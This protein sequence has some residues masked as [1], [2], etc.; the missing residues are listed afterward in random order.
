MTSFLYVNHRNQS[1]SVR[2]WD[3]SPQ[4][5]GTYQASVDLCVL[6]STK[7]YDLPSDPGP[8]SSYDKLSLQVVLLAAGGPIVV[9]VVVQQP[10]LSRLDRVM[11][12]LNEGLWAA[13]RKLTEVMNE[14]PPESALTMP[15]RPPHFSYD[16]ERQRLTLLV[17]GD[18]REAPDSRTGTRSDSDSEPSCPMARYLVN[19]PDDYQPQ[20]GDLLLVVDQVNALRFAGFDLVDYVH[21]GDKANDQLQRFRLSSDE[22]VYQDPP[23]PPV[24]GAGR[25]NVPRWYRVRSTKLPFAYWYTS[26]FLILAAQLKPDHRFVALLT[27][28]DLIE[29][30]QPLDLTERFRGQVITFQ[31]DYRLHN[32]FSGGVLPYLLDHP[33]D[34]AFHQYPGGF[35]FRI[36][37]ERVE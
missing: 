13:H 16:H 29:H 26:R 24:Y 31:V 14:Q 32:P 4:E 36:R 15:P 25:E 37:F 6:E 5:P 8:I 23:E 3:Y 20:L 17:P 30:S 27:P 33:S 22:V 19:E 12:Q 28:E 1:E 35:M 34:G 9:P 18:V 2:S 10:R 7:G 11:L 21:P